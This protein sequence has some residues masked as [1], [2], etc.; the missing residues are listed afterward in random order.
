MSPTGWEALVVLNVSKKKKK[1]VLGLALECKASRL[2]VLKVNILQ[3]LALCYW[4]Y[5]FSLPSKKRKNPTNK[6]LSKAN[7]RIHKHTHTLTPSTHFHNPQS[8]KAGTAANIYPRERREGG[9]GKRHRDSRGPGCT[10]WA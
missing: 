7:T 8:H 6:P 9:R 4:L 10:D 3:L 5:S 2:V 1:T